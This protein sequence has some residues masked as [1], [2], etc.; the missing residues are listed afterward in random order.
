MMVQRFGRIV[1][2]TVLS[3]VMAFSQDVDRSSAVKSLKV[4]V[5]LVNVDVYVTDDEGRHVAGL[6]RDYFRVWEDKIEQK[7]ESFATDDA[8]T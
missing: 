1:F 6:E 5:E 8:P 2:A 3:S 4:D 7:I